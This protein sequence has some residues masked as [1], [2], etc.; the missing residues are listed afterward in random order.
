MVG[1]ISCTLDCNLACKYCF[2]G[3]GN[4]FEA[5]HVNEIN[6]EFVNGTNYF[7]SFINQLYKYNKGKRTTI[8]WHGGEPTLIKA[9]NLAKVMQYQREEKHNI[10]W[11]MQ[12]NGTLFTDE[13]IEVLREY[14]VRVGISLDGLRS[15]HDKYRVTKNGKPTFN[16]VEKNIEKMQKKGIQC[17]VLVTITDNNV[18]DLCE[19]YEYLTE[20]KL[21][22]SYNALYPKP[23]K[24]YTT[25]FEPLTFSEMICK[26]FDKW[27]TDQEGKTIISPFE[28]II[29][30]IL[31]PQ[32]GIPACH[33]QQNCS[34]SFVAI[35]AKGLLY[36]CEHWIS[37][38]NMNFGHIE[39]GLDN[40]LKK[41]TF[42]DNRVEQLKINEKCSRCKIFRFCYGGCPWSAYMALHSINV[43]DYSICEGRKKIIKHIYNYLKQNYSGNIPELDL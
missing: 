37:D 5:P 8:I 20:H 34:K 15:H 40:Y 35:D 17:S 30:G 6:R 14:D 24:D 2:E 25:E 10:L 13:Y 43:P 7:N 39:D 42:L 29:E 27:I 16:K 3:N 36:P 38:A 11:Q 22:F 12:T 1:L 32:Y 26:L 4:R 33:W 21:C 23:D 18:M 9:E 31:A 41:T 28:Q 19:I